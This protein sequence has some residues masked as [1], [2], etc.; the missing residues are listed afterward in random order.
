MS[1]IWSSASSCPRSCYIGNGWA[2]TSPCPRTCYIGNN[3]YSA[4]SC[5]GTCYIGNNWSSASTCPRTYI[6]DSLSSAS[7]SGLRLNKRE[8]R[9]WW[10]LPPTKKRHDYKTFS[11]NIVVTLPRSLCRRKA[12]RAPPQWRGDLSWSRTD[13]LPN[14]KIQLYCQVSMLLHRN[15]S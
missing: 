10:K 3:W 2:S 6:G 14:T 1:N 9:L 12:A 8:G 13:G 11:T 4:S 7:C 15:V 5:P